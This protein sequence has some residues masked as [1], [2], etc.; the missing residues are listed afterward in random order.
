VES[1]GECAAAL[2]RERQ[3]IERLRGA[4][5]PPASHDLTA[6]LL[7]HTEML[8]TASPAP[9]PAQNRA[10]R[11][12]AFTAGGTAAAAGVLAVSAFALAGDTLPEAGNAVSGSLVQHTSQLPVAGGQLNEEQLIQL[13]SEGW[14][15]PEL[16][17]LGFHVQSARTTTVQGLPAVELRLWDGQHYATILEQHTMPGQLNASPQSSAAGELRIVS[18]KPWTATYQTPAGIL[19]FESD[20][21]AE[22]AD[23][24]VPV[25]TKLSA[26]AAEGI[27]AGPNADPPSIQAGA[28]GESLGERL[29]RGIRKIAEM[30][31]P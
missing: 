4:E 21:P 30:L 16:E 31:T 20:L 22:Q 11:V 15:C 1:C 14:A 8:A 23:D 18:S 19:T 9:A 29:Q 3:Y 5:V 6:R 12:L 24:A 2:R 10:A 17:S 27:N 28:P 25:L 7:A 26:L 13:R